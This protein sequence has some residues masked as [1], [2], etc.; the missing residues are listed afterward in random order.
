MDVDRLHIDALV[1]GADG[2]TQAHEAEIVQLAARRK[3]P[4][5]YP[6]REFVEAGGLIAYAV[7]YPDLYRQLASHIDKIL[8]G[9]Q[10][11][12]M[13]IEQ[14]TKFELVIN[15]ATANDQ[16]IAVPRALVVRADDVIR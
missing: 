6:S 11:G 14:P 15:L 12:E 8:K 10:P 7:N 3:L 5:V 9:A 1:V 13:P 2:V 16:G 4:V